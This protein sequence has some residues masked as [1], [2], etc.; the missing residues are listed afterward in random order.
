MI[1]LISACRNTGWLEPTVVDVIPTLRAESDI[2]VSEEVAP[3]ELFAHRLPP[4][5]SVSRACGYA[6]VWASWLMMMMMWSLLKT[7]YCERDELLSWMALLNQT[8]KLW[9][10]SL[11]KRL[12]LGSYSV[13]VTANIPGPFIL[14][15]DPQGMLRNAH[16]KLDHIDLHVHPQLFSLCLGFH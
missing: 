7:R 6:L 3:C 9:G 13:M 4:I 10:E 8:N 2:H 15:T 11:L 12:T 14:S 16:D 5:P 1:Y